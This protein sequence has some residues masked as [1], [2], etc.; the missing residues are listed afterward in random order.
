MKY[1]DMPKGKKLIVDDDDFEFVSRLNPLLREAKKKDYFSVEVAL[2]KK[3]KAYHFTLPHFIKQPNGSQVIAYK[4]KNPLDLRKE[5]LILAN[6]SHFNHALGLNY[7]KKKK[8]SKYRGVSFQKR[9]KRWKWSIMHEG[10]R[11]QNSCR[12]EKAAA[13]AYNEKA[14]DLY[15][16]LAYQNKI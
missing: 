16:D 2:W 1:I 15:G 13:K 8:T 5:N 11:Y 7:S 12:T 6:Y 3:N 10:V 14:I 9:D 4:N